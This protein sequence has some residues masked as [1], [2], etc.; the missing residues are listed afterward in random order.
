VGDRLPDAKINGDKILLFRD[1]NESQK[2]LSISVFNTIFVK[3]CETSS[4]WMPL[5]APPESQP[6]QKEVDEDEMPPL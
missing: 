3:Y 2:G 6:Q 1:T 4:Y 5:P